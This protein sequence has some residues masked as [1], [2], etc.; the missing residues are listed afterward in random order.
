MYSTRRLLII[1]I[2]TGCEEFSY[3]VN[4]NKNSILDITFTQ[5]GSGAYPDT[6]TRHFAINLKNGNVIKASDAFIT[7]SL[8]TLRTKLDGKLHE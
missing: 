5:D 7:S 1:V 3:K 6:Q 4:Y 8:P 2:S